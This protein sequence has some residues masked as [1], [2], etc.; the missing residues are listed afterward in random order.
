MTDSGGDPLVSSVALVLKVPLQELYALLWRA[1]V[2]DIRNPG[3]RADRGR[4]TS[5]VARGPICPDPAAHDSA[6]EGREAYSQAVG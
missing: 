1:G 4:R 3:R 6:A 5:Q 2:V